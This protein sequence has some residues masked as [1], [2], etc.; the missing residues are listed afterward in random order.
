MR[1]KKAAILRRFICE[2]ERGTELFRCQRKMALR[3]CPLPLHPLLH[4]AAFRSAAQ[5]IS[6]SAGHALTP[7]NVKVHAIVPGT[8]GDA[9]TLE[10]VGSKR[11]F[12]A[13]VTDMASGAVV[14]VI[15]HAFWSKEKVLKN[16]ETVSAL[17]S[18]CV[19]E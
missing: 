11:G 4:F 6:L 5:A 18:V 14:A 15:S 17:A 3:E 10:L 13:E 9:P 12:T 8:V 2:D 19:G 7:V 16:K 1:N